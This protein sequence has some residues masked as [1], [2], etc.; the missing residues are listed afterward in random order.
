M[1]RD[2]VELARTIAAEA[3]AGQVDKLG[4]DYIH[5]PAWV[6][7]QVHTPVQKAAAWLH[8]TLEDTSLSERDLLDRGIPMEV[9]FIVA[10]LTRRPGV[11]PE[12]YYAEIRANE[13]ARAVKRADVSH[14]M[15]AE[16]LALL[17]EKTRNRLV[18]KY[19]HA[20]ESLA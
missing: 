3:H 13:D 8:D 12:Q 1:G 9:V 14:N 15:L 4:V 16:R 6:A 19:T 7:S 17:V 11:P 2:I 20:L 18:R 5:H 10:L